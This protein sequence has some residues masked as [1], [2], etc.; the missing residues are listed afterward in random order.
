MT[1]DLVRERLAAFPRLQAPSA[2]LVQ[3]AVAV[4]L[5][6]NRNQE[7]CFLLTRRAEALRR[8]AGQWALP[9]G[10]LDAGE[11]PVGAA[12]RE[13]EEELG[14]D[15]RSADH[16]GTLDDY[17]TQSGFVIT[18]VVLLLGGVTRLRPNPAEVAA[19]YRIPLKLLRTPLLGSVDTGP[20][21]RFRL[22]GRVINPPTAAILHQ[23][24]ELIEF[25]RITRVGH[26]A[27]PR[28]TWS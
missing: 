22:L 6:P 23:L 11:S 7:P 17:V 10:R 1:P 2:G 9:G 26:F 15:G 18:P 3:A 20:S 5:L 16:A 21:V 14:I 24:I 27:Q 13:L 4:A 25:G 12:R 19:A 8:H 28:F